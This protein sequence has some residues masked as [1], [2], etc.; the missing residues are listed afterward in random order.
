MQNLG[1][2]KGD[3]MNTYPE[4]IYIVTQA[5]RRVLLSSPPWSEFIT[6]WRQNSIEVIVLSSIE[7]ALDLQFEGL[8]WVF[9]DR[10]LGE[11]KDIKRSVAKLE[12]KPNVHGRHFGT[13][14]GKTRRTVNKLRALTNKS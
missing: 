1:I 4:K 13:K 3:E 2:G 12:Q 6:A 14:P 11:F 5:E 9:V 8:T 10:K 7:A